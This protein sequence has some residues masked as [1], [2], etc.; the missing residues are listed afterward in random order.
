M[1]I[2]IIGAEGLLG[3]ALAEEGRGL[4]V[5]PATSR[6]ADIRDA[7]AVRGLF[8]RTRP[9]CSILA[10]AFTDVDGC[11]RE[12]ERAHQ[13]NCVGAANVARAAR[14]S[15]SR[16][17][18]ISTDYVFDGKKAAPYETTDLTKPL[19]I[20]GRSKAAGEAAVQE[21]LP[22]SCIVR[23]ARLFGT[24]GKCFP[25]SILRLAETQ[26]EIAVVNDQIGSPTFNR[27]L[28]RAVLQLAGSGACGI[29][30]ATNSGTCSWFEFAQET[31]RAAGIE[32]VRVRAISS[33]ESGRPA[34]RPKYSVLSDA[35]LR[36]CGIFMRPWPSA[37][38]AYIEEHRR[39]QQEAPR[40]RGVA[41][42]RLR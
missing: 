25:A 34:A 30:H 18:F 29:V 4:E 38:G 15:S 24:G 26:D 20:Y 1:R 2:L 33:E 37:L 40:S 31:L 14:E 19:S 41:A 39:E 6:E 16:L 42:G 11:E 7:T 36:A 22:D 27:D 13:V 28:A 12:P 35:S 32:D 10:A 17:I 21:I 9:D 8:T 3:R 5:I 23:T